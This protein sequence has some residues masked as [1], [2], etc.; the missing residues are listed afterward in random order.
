VKTFPAIG[1]LF[2]R[3]HVITPMRKNV[4]SMKSQA[5]SLWCLIWVALSGCADG[6]P[7]DKTLQAEELL[8]TA[9]FT[10]KTIATQSQLER[11]TK[12]PQ[13]KIVRMPSRE[14]EVYLWADVSGC[15]CFYT[16]TRQNYENLFTLQRESRQGQRIEWYDAQDND[17]LWGNSLDWEDA[18]LGR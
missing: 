7:I 10:L 2:S 5:V 8:G 13:R 1:I 9:G 14:G 11:L 12:L 6:P 3:H 4:G 16:G 18:L 15:R 17:P